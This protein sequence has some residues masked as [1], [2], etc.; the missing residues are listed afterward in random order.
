MK[1]ENMKINGLEVVIKYRTTANRWTAKN[2]TTHIIGIAL[3]GS[4]IHDLGY[5]SF[6]IEENCIFFL[7][8]RDDFNVEVLEKGVS[9]S[10]HFTTTAPVETDSF[11]IK[12]HNPVVVT[13]LLEKIDRYHTVSQTGTHMALS[14]FHR[15][16]SLFCTIL[17]KNYA[18]RDERMFAIRTYMDQHFTEPDCLTNTYASCSLSRR[19]FDALFRA[20]F[21]LTPSRY[22]T[23][24]K[25]A[26][27]RQLLH[28]DNLTVSQIAQMC[29]Y[30]DVYYFSNSF[31]RETGITPSA[32]RAAQK[33]LPTQDI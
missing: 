31:K 14:Y 32:Y 12:I 29:G 1:F 27:A 16:C 10:I 13:Q 15:L 30:N 22:L 5:Q 33:K 6:C 23:L 8:Q 21:D 19:R 25:I 3:S 7:N 4:E 9:Y 26:Y 18:P 2:R 24:L 11:C 17:Q 20:N 28:T